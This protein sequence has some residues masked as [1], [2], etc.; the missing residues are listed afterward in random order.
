MGINAARFLPARSFAWH[1][2]HLCRTGT[3]SGLAE[4]ALQCG[5]RRMTAARGCVPCSG[6]SR[7]NVAMTDAVKSLGASGKNNVLRLVCDTVAL[8]RQ[9]RR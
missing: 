5:Y 2:P 8:R 1:Q 3:P 7:S 4:A 9:A 6:I